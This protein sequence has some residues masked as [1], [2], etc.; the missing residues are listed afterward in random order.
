[1]WRGDVAEEATWKML[2]VTYLAIMAKI[3][4]ER[5]QMEGIN[6]RSALTLGLTAA[7]TPLLAWATPAAAYSPTEGKELYPGVRLIDLGKRPSEISA[8]KT[9]HMMDVTFAPGAVF[10]VGAPMEADMVC[11]VPV[12]ELKVTHGPAGK[13]TEY[14]VKEGEVYSC[15]KGSTLE[16][17]TN[18]G[19]V[20]AVMRVIQLETT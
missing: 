19:S 2:V 1:L 8:Y 5:K 6:R 16:G 4:M 7:A 20:M 15:A 14:T 9:V 10:P 12:G 11:H 13:M 17:A 18:T 3:Q